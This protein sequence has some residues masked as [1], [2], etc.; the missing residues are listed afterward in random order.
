MVNKK[1]YIKTLEAVIAIIIV[2]LVGYILIPS[3]REPAPD[4][5]SILKGSQKAID[6]SIQFNETIRTYLTDDTIT[7]EEEQIMLKAINNIIKKYTPF[8]YDYTCVVCSNPGTCLAD[9]TPGKS[10]YM[11]DV[12]VASS[13]K[14]QN[15]KIVRVWFW[16]KPTLPSEV[17]KGLNDC[18][19]K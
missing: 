9:Y 3:S 10:I 14:K 5:P 8:G 2:I 15:P 19:V 6:Q 4:V 1:G 12:F 11:T 16:K 7:K 13:E 17:P 18:A